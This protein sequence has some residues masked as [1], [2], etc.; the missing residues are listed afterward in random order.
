[1]KTLGITTG[2]HDTSAALVIDGEIIAI[3]EEERFNREKHTGKF[4]INAIKFC[5]EKGNISIDQIDDVCIGMNWKER[6]LARL[7]MRMK[8]TDNPELIAQ[9]MSQSKDD[10]SRYSSVLRTLK[11]GFGYKGKITFYDHYDCHASVCY[12]PSGFDQSAILI[13]DGAGE[14]ASAR[15]YK[16]LG[17]KFENLFQ[18]DYPNSVGRFYGWITDYLGFHIESDEGK[19]MGLAPYGDES[20]VSEMRKL[21]EIKEDGSYQFDY[22]YFEFMRD[23]SKGFSDKFTD[24]FGPKRN[25]YDD[26]T[27]HHRNIARAA[28]VILEEVVV[29][30]AKLTKHL[31]GEDNLCIGGGVALNCVANGKIVKSGLFKNVYIYPASGDNGTSIGAALYAYYFKKSVKVYYRKNQSP[32]LGYEADEYRILRSLRKHHLVYRKSEN[33]CKETAELLANNKIVGWFQGRSEVGPRALGNRSILANPRDPNNKDRVNNKIKFRESFRPFAPS[34]LKEYEKDYFDMNTDSPYMI[35][36]F[37]SKTNNKD[38][39]PAVVHVDG[40]ARVQ[41]VTKARN[42]KYWNLINEFYKITGTPLVL[43]TSF[44]RA[45]EVMVNTPEQAIE[46]FLGSQLDVLVLEDYIIIK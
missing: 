40:T 3:G 45:G 11:E 21:V 4:P 26:L 28:Q 20:L 2:I 44:N 7:E 41:S 6:G 29:G 19:I 42:E 35:I 25:K 15:I 18:T 31:T 32:Y 36:A 34:V 38:L 24:I 8:F 1:M 16:A 12:F 39:I 10:I 5:L 13:L 27:Q 23:N 43:N 9:A 17:N 37:D 46:T 22:T 30:M 33:I 14:R